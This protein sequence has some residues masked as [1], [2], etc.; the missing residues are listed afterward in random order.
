MNSYQE[1]ETYQGKYC[2]NLKSTDPLR[3]HDQTEW[4]LAIWAQE[5]QKEEIPL[6]K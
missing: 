6:N 4:N 3:C 1:T 2:T 5:W